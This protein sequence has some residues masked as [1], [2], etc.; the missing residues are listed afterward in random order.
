MIT[1]PHCGQ[2]NPETNRF[3][4]A[5]AAVLEGG[6]EQAREVR[7]TVTIVFCDLVGSTA[8]GERTDPELLRELMSSYHATLRVILERHG[9]TVEKFVGDAAMA[10]FGVPIVHEDDAQRAV[11]AAVEMREA[12]IELG[13]SVRM[14]ISTGEVAAGTG[15][16]LVTGD[17][18][19]VAARFEQA[20]EPGEILI[21]VQTERLVSGLVRAEA[22]APLQLKGKS[23]AVPAFRLIEVLPDVP[24][25]TAPIDAPFVGRVGELAAL[26]AACAQA[27]EERVPQLCT[28]VGPPGIGKSR[29]VREFLAGERGRARV[30]IGRCLPY[31][32]GITYWPLGEIVRQVGGDQPR[33]AIARIV[34]GTEGPLVA[35]RLA[36]AISL[37]PAGGSPEEISWAARKLVEALAQDQPVIAVVDD[38]HWAEPALLDLL[39][40]VATFATGVPLLMLCTARPDVFES[41]PSWSNPR[42][43]AA[44]V[45]LEPLG[46]GEAESLIDALEEMDQPTRSR[47]VAAAEGNP[48]FVEQFLAMWAEGHDGELVIPPTVH[49]LLSARLDRLEP[50]ERAVVERASVEGRLFHR[51]A[52][53]EMLPAGARTAVGSHLISLVRKEFIRPDTAIFAG[54][55]GFRFGHVLIRDAAYESIPKRLRAELHERFAA[56]FEAR[57]GDQTSQYDEILGFHLE[58]AHRYLVDLGS[59][60]DALAERAAARLGAAGTRALDRGDMDGAGNLLERAV[61]LLDDSDPQR[62]DLEVEL[63]EAWLESGRLSETEELL[64]S[65]VAR[66][67]RTGDPQLEARATV[68]LAL[69]RIQTQSSVEHQAIRTELEPLVGVFEAAGDDRGSADVLRLLGRLATWSFGYVEAADFQ[70]RALA[71]ARA[72]GDERREAGIMRLIVSDALWGPEPVAPALARCRAILEHTNNRRVQ[73]N[74]LVRIGGL[75]GLAGRFDAARETIAEARA[76]MDDLGLRHLKA[77][78]SDVAV[79]VEMLAGDYEAA[80]AEAQVAYAALAEMGDRTYQSSEAHLIA[81]ALEAQGRVDDAE[82]WLERSYGED[83]LDPDSLTLRAQILMRRDRLEDAERLARSALALGPEPSV[84]QFADPRFTLAQILAGRAENG[85]AREQAERCL[86]RYEAKGIVPLME[87]ARALIATLPPRPSESA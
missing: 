68:G 42:R 51:G 75:E 23:D 1:C 36:G 80:E 62:I 79:L 53:T 44:L 9:G 17:A 60:S 18:V 52:V 50:A 55:D 31:G 5:C 67:G 77:H 54:D 11:R 20:A 81:Q 45:S 4:G 82:R 22:I 35:D 29:I 84:P 69:V 32:E 13:L 28:I 37:G 63:G 6:S 83:D 64:E 46:Q 25:F 78:S 56:W 40:Y 85:A 47:I 49:A 10:V 58:R 41:R 7:K 21:G 15:E 70:E 61:A 16:T 48:L 3:C 24:A 71:H 30:V 34:G 2:Q 12:V 57:L 76:V 74:C 26:R 33:D 19:N 39:E 43:N 8:L 59:P 66:A 73:A 14:G 65:T 87:Q 86:Q 72:A 27:V 38:I